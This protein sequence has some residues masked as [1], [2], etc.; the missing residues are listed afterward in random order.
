[1]EFYGTPQPVAQSSRQQ[2]VV[3]NKITECDEANGNGTGVLHN[4]VAYSQ[5]EVFMKK[6]DFTGLN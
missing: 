2:H 1:M 5:V 6:G 4:V 3:L